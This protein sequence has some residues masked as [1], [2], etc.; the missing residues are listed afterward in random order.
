MIWRNKK[1]ARHAQGVLYS[2]VLVYEDGT[3]R[4]L[5]SDEKK[6]LETKFDGGDGNRPYVKRG[7]NSKTP[8]GKLGGFLRAKETSEGR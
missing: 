6:Y 8:D 7:Y 1:K 4:E 3:Y 5:T 2:Y